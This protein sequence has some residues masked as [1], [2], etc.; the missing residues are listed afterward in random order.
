VTYELDFPTRK[1]EKQYERFLSSLEPDERQ[2]TAEKIE[3]LQNNPRPR[4]CDKIK[5]NIYKIRFGDWRVVYRIYKRE[6]VVAI[7][8]IGVRRERFHREFR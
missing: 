3:D 4:G 7:A 5:G 1:V 2:A 8:K 6:R